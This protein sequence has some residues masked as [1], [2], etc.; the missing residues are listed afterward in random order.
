MTVS[1]KN[2]INSIICSDVIDIFGYN[3]NRYNL[4]HGDCLSEIK[5]I[6]NSSIDSVVCDPPYP[7]I[8]RE[9]G[10]WTEPE[11]HTL[12]DSIIPE[13]KRV[14]KPHGSAIF[15]LQPN[16]ETPGSVRPWLWEFLAKYSKEWNLI[17]DIYAWNFTCMPTTH[18]SRKYGLLRPSVKM[19]VWL[20]PIDCYKNQDAILWEQADANKAHKL[21]NRALKKYPSGS[22]MREGR[23]IATANERGGSTPFNLIPIS[24]GNNKR[25]GSSH[26]AATPLDLCR[27]LVSYVTKPNGTVLDPFAGSGTIGEASIM[28]GFN[29]IG[30]ER[31][32]EYIDEAEIRLHNATVSHEIIPIL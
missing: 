13:I 31:L 19:C 5:K 24:S 30:I 27:W 8:Q 20:G 14:L 3:V 17:Q 2:I 23:C 32:K 10:V 15:I 9:Y 6:E 26:G 4:I 12:M 28:H 25:Q 22:S 11:W 16:H 29:Y 7:E 18:C 1:P 21:S